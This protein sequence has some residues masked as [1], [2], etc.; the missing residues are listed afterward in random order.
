MTE[1]DAEMVSVAVA[2]GSRLSEAVPLDDVTSVEDAAAVD[3]TVTE[4]LMEDD[5]EAVVDSAAEADMTIDANAEGVVDGAGIDAEADGTADDD[6]VIDAE[7]DG[8]ADD[9]AVLET[10]E[11]V[12]VDDGGADKV[13]DTVTDAAEA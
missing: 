10:A 1:L 4:P 9:D 11:R 13:R 5:A 3:A 12:E 8:T 6:A 7:A 2:D